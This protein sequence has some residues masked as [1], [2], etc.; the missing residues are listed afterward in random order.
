MATKKPEA[1]G[2]LGFP[3]IAAVS[4]IQGAAGQPTSRH[5]SGRRLVRVNEVK[6][7]SS[8]AL[9]NS[10][11]AGSEPVSLS[12]GASPR[13]GACPSKGHMHKGCLQKAVCYRFGV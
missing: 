11:T 6:C 13:P 7:V 5:A 8:Y 4:H 1:E 9:C 10:A 3:V 12:V 2:S